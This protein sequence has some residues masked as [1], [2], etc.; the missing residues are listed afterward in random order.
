MTPN[1][2]PLYSEISDLFRHHQKSF[3]GSRWD[4]T[5]SGGERGT[6]SPNQDVSIKPLPSIARTR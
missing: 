3:S 1:D 6:H 4:I 2:I 5:Q